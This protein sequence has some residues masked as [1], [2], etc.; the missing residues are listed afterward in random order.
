MENTNTSI[1]TG[2]LSM[3][4]TMELVSRKWMDIAAKRLIL[5]SISTTL[6]FQCMAKKAIP[7]HKL[8]YDVFQK[9]DCV[10]CRD[11]IEVNNGVTKERLEF[12]QHDFKIN[13]FRNS[14]SSISLQYFNDST[15]Y[16]FQINMLSI[17]YH[18]VR[19]V[20][21]LKRQFAKLD[22]KNLMTE[23]LS[24]FKVSFSGDEVLIMSSERPEN[25]QIKQLF[26]N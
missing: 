2:K 4:L 25:P 1:I 5:I 24:T 18:S 15:Y 21:S 6:L 7:D 3:P 16:Q 14:E 19:R 22:R 23:V 26:R 12:Y 8:F 13:L 17:K 10:L 9:L 20:D 11:S